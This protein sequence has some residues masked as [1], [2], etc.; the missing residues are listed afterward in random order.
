LTHRRHFWF[1]L[2][3]LLL[4]LAFALRVFRLGEQNIWWDEGLAIWAVRKSLVETTLWTASDVHPPLFF[5]TL[6]PWVRLVGQSEFAARFLTLAWGMLAAAL[7]YALG[8]RLGGRRAGLLSLALVAVSP[9]AVWWSMELR[10]YMLAGLA[11]LAAVYTSVRWLAG[12]SPRWLAGYLLAA[13]AAVYTVYLTGIAIAAINLAV[14]AAALV[15]WLGRRRYARWLLVQVA[16]VLLFLPWWRFASARM[17]SWSAVEA[18]AAP[19]FVARLWATLLATGVSTDIDRAGVATGV[20]VIGVV[21]AAGI[22]VWLA[23]RERGGGW[24]DGH[25]ERMRWVGLGMLVLFLILPPL[26]VWAATQ[27]RSLFYTPAVEARYFL[28]FAAPVY[29]LVACV[30]SGLWGRSRVLGGL[31]GLAVF[32]P[33]LLH[34][35]G[36]YAERRLRDELQTLVL[37]IWTQAEPGD[38]VVLVSGNRYPIFRY[39]YD[40]PWDIDGAEPSYVFPVDN[41][42]R[43]EDRPSVIEFP[44]RGSDPLGENDWQDRLEEITESHD[45]IWLAEVDSHLQ[46]PEG[47][48]EEWLSEHWPR[49]LSEGYGANALHLYAKGGQE[50]VVMGVTSGMP[51]TR[52]FT[53]DWDGDPSM[54]EPGL[55]G[56]PAR[57]LLPGDTLN[58]MVFRDEMLTLALKY[59]GVDRVWSV[60]PD[61]HAARIELLID[62]RFPA[63]A[64]ELVVTK[65]GPSEGQYRASVGTIWIRDTLPPQSIPKIAGDL[66]FGS[67]ARLDGVGMGA[68]RVSPGGTMAVDLMWD[69]NNENAP[70]PVPAP[71]VFIHLVGPPH[72]ESGDPVWAGQDGLPSS[73]PWRKGEVFD[74]HVL[75]LDPA[76][77]P[78]EYQIEVGLYNPETGERYPVTGEDAGG[79][80]R[81]V[82]VGTMI[83]K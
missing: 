72:P 23:W 25:R 50:P 59:R 31:V 7:A 43:W 40:R 51:G 69:V 73:G 66:V 4:L 37:A 77:P 27:P 16:L 75:T 82:V 44:D 45:R 20:F 41:P 15:G 65:L 78:G 42:P 63:G 24:P 61:R 67:F 32:A 53:L 14:L 76:A 79:A 12:D 30:L 71:H 29:V 6:W 19:G 35:P 60:S 49:V 64:Y 57:S 17:K 52:R 13:L 55:I 26:A 11:V 33:L 54:A 9:L 5:W 46:D 70:I 28:P 62:D 18:P 36:Y 8:R 56:M 39:Y 74:R 58:L 68:A 22:L 80:N 38:A 81:R 34:L 10:M 2:P 47:R 1:L 83:V 21:I 48:V 3:V